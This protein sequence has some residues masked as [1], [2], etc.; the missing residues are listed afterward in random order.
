MPSSESTGAKKCM[1]DET[2]TSSAL[3]K[4]TVVL[5]GHDYNTTK[6]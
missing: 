6:T 4:T 2:K 5:L 1:N 3:T